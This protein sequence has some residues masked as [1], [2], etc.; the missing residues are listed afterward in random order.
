MVDHIFADLG[1]QQGFELRDELLREL[2]AR[3]ESAPVSV[4]RP[5]LS[6]VPQVDEYQ[7]K[8]VE[9]EVHTMRVVA[10][11]GSG[12]TQTMLNRVLLRIQQ[13][14]NPELV[15][16]LTFDNSA[17]TS[18][19]SKLREQTERLGIELQSLQIKTLNAFGFGVLRNYLSEEYKGIIPQYRQIKLIREVIDALKERSLERYRLLPQNIKQRFYLEFFSLLKNELFDPRAPDAQRLSEFITSSP[20]LAPFFEPG[21]TQSKIRPIIEAL[22]WLFMAYERAMQRE[23]LMDFDDQKLRCYLALT[24]STDL[25]YR[26]QRKFAEIIVDEFQDINRLD[27]AL[28]QVLAEQSALVVT[29]DDDQAIYGFRGCSP[30]YIINLQE[31][32]GREVT[33]FELSINYRNPANLVRCADQLIRHNVN[34]IPK[35]PIAARSDQADIKV[36]GTVSAGLEARFIVSFI[37]KVRRANNNLPFNDIAVLYRTNAQSLPLQVEFILNDIPYYVR[38]QDNILTNDV[39]ERLLGFLRLKLSILKGREPAVKDAMLTLHAYFRYIDGATHNQIE[40]LLV[41]NSDFFTLLASDALR[42][43]APWITASNAFQ[44]VREAIDASSLVDTLGVIAKRFKGVRGMVGD[45]EDALEDR[46]PLGEVYELAANF[47]GDTQEFVDTI[48]RALNRARQSDAGKEREHGLALLTYFK[49]KGL[50][51]HT[52]ILT[53]C[54]EGLIPHKRA[55]IEDER[56]LFYVAMT[57]AS[58]NLLISYVKSSVQQS[59]SPSRFITEA[60][61]L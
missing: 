33:P 11:A 10:P 37:R 8:V 34:R 28:V 36:V 40:S 1:F 16:L 49:S 55:P 24:E 48:E 31:S 17:A 39:L 61:L 35:R 30:Y 7:R 54:N 12:K 15:L 14:M 59:V 19:T 2:S 4:Q 46:L 42:Q 44:S 57:R 29:G 25:R 6:F 20:Q 3:L 23:R 51:W 38:E 26:L 5:L 43:I 18:L 21:L 58:S 47:G 60:G 41:R 9:A 56:R 22:I 13:G 50:Q 32:I 52:V 45:L 27:F 53:T